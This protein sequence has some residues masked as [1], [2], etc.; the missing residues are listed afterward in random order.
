MK[1]MDEGRA[2]MY[3]WVLL[4]VLLVIFAVSFLF[5]GLPALRNYGNSFQ[6]VRVLTVS[7]EGKTTVA[8]DLANASFS[9]LSQGKSPEDL[10]AQNNEKMSAVIKF[11][12]SQGVS[13]KDIKTTSYNLQPDYKYDE[14]IR[15]SY[16]VGYTLTQ[17]LYVK[18]R[19]LEKVAA[20]I[21]GLAPLGVNQIGGVD[22]TVDDKEKFLAVARAEAFSRAKDKAAEMAGQNGARL[23]RV[24]NISETPIAFPYFN[25][26]VYKAEMG[27]GGAPSA[28]PAPTIEPGSEEITTNVSVTYELL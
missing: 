8:P 18:I 27:M 20:I 15:I 17:T 7:G 3:F 6:P 14:N 24:M 11:V 22:F 21:G 13:D 23:G 9:V 12:K 10:A 5:Y 2:K 28:P 1:N 25:G 19:D 26:G 4:D 16:I